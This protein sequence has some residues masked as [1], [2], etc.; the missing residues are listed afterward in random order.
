MRILHLFYNSLPQ[1]S[2]ASIRNRDL[3]ESQYAI[4]NMEPWVITSPIQA[5]FKQKIERIGGVPYIR[6]ASV[7]S[8]LEVNEAI[9]SVGTRFRKLLRM[10]GFYFKIGTLAKKLKPEIIHSHSIYL[11]GIAGIMVSRALRVPHVYEVRSLW[12]ERALSEKKS[13]L[14]RLLY[15]I[16]RMAESRVL[17]SADK[18]IAIN[19]NLKQILVESRGVPSD[20]ILIVPNAVNLARIH[21]GKNDVSLSDKSPAEW[22]FGYV[23]TISPLEGL[24]LLVDALNMLKK[25]GITNKVKLFGGGMDLENLKAYVQKSGMG[26][27]IELVGR[28]N[29]DEIASAYQELDIIVNP[30]KNTF[31]TAN[32]TP[33]KP[34]E[35]MGYRKLIIASDIG[36]MK[37][38]ITDKETGYL[39]ASDNAM[40]LSEVIETILKQ[41]VEET[42]KVVN[43]GYAHVEQNRSWSANA[44]SYNQIYS[45][46]I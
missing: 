44:A 30:R 16:V 34:L 21:E 42:A 31:L 28:V 9:S 33:L 39:F 23:G 32:V 24:D 26:D 10:V 43:Q 29:N 3:V 27:Q 1:I 11:M 13:L 25:R 40:A 14:G 17:K 37:E 15:K 35:A 36:G 38:L 8:D 4:K 18:I 2:G 19:V 20:K 22:V 5:P 12:E 41:P 46:L 45:D 6:T 7:N